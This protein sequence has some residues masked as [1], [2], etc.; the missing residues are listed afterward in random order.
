MLQKMVKRELEAELS[1]T[2]LNFLPSGSGS[3]MWYPWYLRH[4]CNLDLLSS[5]RSSSAS[6]WAIGHPGWGLLLMCGHIW[7]RVETQIAEIGHRAALIVNVP[8]FAGA[9]LPESAAGREDDAAAADSS[10]Q[11]EVDVSVKDGG[12]ML[13][14]ALTPDLRWQS[15]AAELALSVRGV[16]SSPQVC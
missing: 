16:K 15:G 14:T 3:C 12:M 7:H 10:E 11:L 1:C 2:G 6:W 13:V 9:L 8:C 4:A 5:P